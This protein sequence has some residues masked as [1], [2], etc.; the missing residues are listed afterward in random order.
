MRII[1]SVLVCVCGL[2]V[3][4]PSKQVRFNIMKTPS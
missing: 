2:L 4:Y 1:A 3:P